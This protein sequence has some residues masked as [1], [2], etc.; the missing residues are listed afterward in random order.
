MVRDSCISR[1][2]H[3]VLTPMNPYFAT[4]FF[5]ASLTLA[6]EEGIAW[7]RIGKVGTT[8][9]SALFLLMRDVP[10][11]QIQVSGPRCP[12]RASDPAPCRRPWRT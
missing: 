1:S 3:G 8:A 2:G 12:A 10:V 5:P 9:W 7:C 4:K 11:D 6:E